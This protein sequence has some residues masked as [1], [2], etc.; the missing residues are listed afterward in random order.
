M[1]VTNAEVSQKPVQAKM[2]VP[3]QGKT[4]YFTLLQA[5][6]LLFLTLVISIGGW[7]AAGKYYFWNDL[8]M[9]RISEQLVYLQKKVQAEPKKTEYRVAL[10]YT[11]FLK[12]D[13]RQ[14]IKELKQAIEIDKNNFD[15][16]YNLGLVYSDGEKLDDAL[17][18][19]QKAVEIAPRDYKGHLQKG[20]VYRK[21]KMF[22]E[23]IDSLAVANKL[24][25]HNAD[26]IYQIGIVAEAKG[27]LKTAVGIY[28]DAL[29]YDPLY[30]DA[31]E[32]LKRLQKK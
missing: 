2:V 18:T 21:M 13:N 8:D 5:G 30:K 31:A 11:H 32:A 27:D 20:I 24:V 16:Y 3:K 22:K 7:Y 9:K 4:E 25:P 28:K 15:A 12:G 23:A 14:A 29:S 17:E 26:I 10:G 19:F 1:S 6:M